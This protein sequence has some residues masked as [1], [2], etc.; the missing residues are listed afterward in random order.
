MYATM[1]IVALTAG[2]TSGKLT[3]NPVWLDDYRAAQTRVTE[4]QKPMIVFVANGKT[5]WENVLR[6]GTLSPTATKLLAEKFVCVYANTNTSRG[7][8]LAD[9]LQV[10]D[11]GLV[12]SD[13]TGLSQAYSLAGDLTGNELVRALETYADADPKDVKKTDTVVTPAAV[14]ATSAGCCSTGGNSGGCGMSKGCCFLGGMSK[15]SG[16]SSGCA[17]PSSSCGSSKSGCGFGGGGFKSLCGFG[18]GWGGG[19]SSGCGMGGGCK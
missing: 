15:G 11:K 17:Q 12:I 14:G 5:G 4:A 9:A 13:K 3:P 1:A 6:D 8:N 16:Q 19:H 2:M 7:R 18:G 10:G